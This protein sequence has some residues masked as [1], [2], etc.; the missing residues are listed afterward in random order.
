MTADPSSLVFG[1]VCSSGLAVVPGSAGAWQKLLIATLVFLLVVAGVWR[2]R[3]L[4]IG[5]LNRRAVAGTKRIKSQRLRR[6]GVLQIMQLA[7]MA[8]RIAS[9]GIVVL[10]LLVWLTF[11]PGVF[12]ETTEWA[13]RLEH[14]ILD[15]LRVVAGGL[16]AALP[17]IGVVVVIFFVTRV[18]Q[19]FLSHYFQSIESGEV[20][21]EVFD[22]TTAETTRRLANVGLWVCAGIVAFPYVPGSDSP[23][24]RGVSILAGLM[25][26]LGSTNLVGQM[27]NGLVLIYTRTL[28]PGDCV[29]I[30]E[31]EGTIEKISLF[32]CSLRTPNEEL[33][34]LPNTKVAEGVKN[35]SRAREGSAVRFV[36]TVTIGYDAPWQQVHEL[37]LAAARSTP[38]V[39][40]DPEPF[41]RQ[42]A[43][44]DF[45]VRYELV[46][47]PA[48]PSR[49]RLVLSHLHG[50]IQQRFH[51]AGLQIMSPHYESDPD[52]PKIP[53]ARTG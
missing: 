22:A 11:L 29:Q 17:G 36:T 25:V 39:R 50:E 48:D 31:V 5:L 43:L 26:S 12:P 38:E 46:F 18:M 42:A 33:V 47:A 6:V 7:R 1:L 8:V 21:S 16:L 34:V 2:G 20:E 10:A 14:L 53:P 44:E 4:L 51:S 52:A 23:I 9:V 49:R 30:G 19:E 15:E 45:Y 13:G 35:F 32:A 3:K 41:V 28:R 37:L 27:I 40:R 24:F